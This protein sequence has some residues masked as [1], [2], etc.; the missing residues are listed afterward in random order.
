MTAATPLGRILAAVALTAAGTPALAQLPP[1]DTGGPQFPLPASTQ[2]PP[3]PAATAPTGLARWFNLSTAPFIPVPVVGVDPDSGTTLGMLPVWIRTNEAHYIDRII[4]PDIVHNPYFG[5]GAHARLYAYPSEDEQWSAVAG[6]KQRVERDLDLEYQVGRGRH[7]HWSLAASLVYDVNGAPRFYGI[8]NRTRQAEQTNYTAEQ[9][10]LWTRVGYNLSRIWQLAYT[11]RLRRVDVEPGTL[12]GIDS[13]EQRF[14]EDALGAE[15]EFL[16]RLSLV[17]DTR[18]DLTTPRRGMQWTAYVGVASRNGLLNDSLYT[19]TGVDAR[20][21]WPVFHDTVLA[22]HVAVR[23]LLRANGVPFWALSSVG[24]DR[25]D[26][27]GQQPLRGFGAGRFT[28]RDSFSAT[29]ELR[30]RLFSFNASSRVDVELTPFVDAGRV[31]SDADTFPL[32]HLHTVGGI[33]FRGVARP[34]VVGYVDIGYGTEGIAV[35]TGINYPF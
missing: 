16:H 17:Y 33:G 1:T 26:L 22:A 18:D 24:G 13:I 25:S 29:L 2:V 15:R 23:Y 8:G 27:G 4:A 12:N 6:I 3:A 28:D 20:A 34:S 31:F 19:D 32:N 14:G 11:M 35:F 21:F 10:V 9:E 30:H 5:W 7:D